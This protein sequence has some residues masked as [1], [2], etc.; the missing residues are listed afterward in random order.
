[1]IYTNSKNIMLCF[2]EARYG[3]VYSWYDTTDNYLTLLADADK[4]TIK[5]TIFHAFFLCLSLVYISWFYTGAV[6]FLLFQLE[7]LNWHYLY[8][9]FTE[10]EF[11]EELWQSDKSRKLRKTMWQNKHSRWVKMRR[12]KRKC[13]KQKKTKFQVKVIKDIKPPNSQRKEERRINQWMK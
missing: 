9:T 10:A 5:K 1:M 8:S 2:R 4:I 13:K 11:T 6:N 7:T 12:Q 3:F